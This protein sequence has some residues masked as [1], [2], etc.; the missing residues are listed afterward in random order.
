[1]DHVSWERLVSGPGLVHLFEFL[2]DVEGQA[3]PA[4][5]A[6][7]LDGKDEPAAITAAALAGVPIAAATLD[8]FVTLYGAEAGNL[9]LK[10]RAIG[11]VY[12]GG[13]IGPRI[14]AK[15]TDGKF[16][17]AF[18]AKGRFRELLEG[19]P[20]RVVVDGDTALYGAARHALEQLGR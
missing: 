20:V 9:A 4:T 15:L 10:L 17:A 14:L 12:L 19:M 8:L 3:V 13:G 1:M 11:G 5:L 7:A 6:G 18:T 16:H 2:R